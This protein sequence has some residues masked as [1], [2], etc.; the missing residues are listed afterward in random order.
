[1]LCQVVL[2]IRLCLLSSG[3]NGPSHLSNMQVPCH[4]SALLGQSHERP[5]RLR[6]CFQRQGHCSGLHTS[7]NPKSY[8]EIP[9]TGPL[10]RFA[11][12]NLILN[13]VLKSQQQGHRPTLRT[14]CSASTLSLKRSPAQIRKVH[15]AQTRSSLC[16][17]FALRS[18]QSSCNA[19]LRILTPKLRLSTYTSL[20]NL[21]VALLCSSG[22]R[23]WGQCISLFAFVSR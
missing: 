14:P 20:S 19:V 17:P 21:H 5:P 15:L 2:C 7:L 16:F 3:C 13:C 23:V 9:A 12:L 11:H 22:Q 4:G 6:P 1:M 18:E 8:T 10:P